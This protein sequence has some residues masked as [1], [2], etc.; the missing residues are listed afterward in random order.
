MIP[1]RDLKWAWFMLFVS[2]LDDGFACRDELETC[3]VRTYDA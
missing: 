1:F 2:F 3:Y